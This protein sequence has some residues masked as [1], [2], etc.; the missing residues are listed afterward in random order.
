MLAL[1][2]H[3]E[4]ARIRGDL[5]LGLT[6]SSID[7][8]VIVQFNGHL[9]WQWFGSPY[10]SSLGVHVNASERTFWTLPS[11]YPRRYY[12]Q[13]ALFTSLN[14]AYRWDN[15]FIQLSIL[16]YYVE[17]LARNPFGTWPLYSVI[18][19]GMGFLLPHGNSK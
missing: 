14:L 8:D 4:K 17:V 7:G 1:G 11:K 18:S 13:N 15:I 5:S 3:Q 9:G 6:P 19:V 12:G 2:V 10:M 16:D